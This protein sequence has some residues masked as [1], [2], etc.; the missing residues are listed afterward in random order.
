ML[1][2]K[3]DTHAVIVC[4]IVAITGLGI[5]F[6]FQPTLV[7]L[8]AHCTKSQ[9]AVVIADRNFFRCLG[10]ACGLAISAAILQATLR[11]NLPTQFAYLTHSSYSLPDR[12]A[13]TEIEWEQI[14][15]AYAQAS[16]SV[17]LFM[18]PVIALCF[19]ACV[20]VRDHG[21]ER[22]KDAQEIEEEKRKAAE[23]ARDPE[24]GVIEPV[25]EPVSEEGLPS[26]NDHVT[27]EVEKR[28]SMSSTLAESSMPPS[29]LEPVLTVDPHH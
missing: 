4:V 8:Q 15:D 20:L 10:G 23:A 28:H 29:Q 18:F 17:F 3:R 14:L 16:H 5:G 9:R 21:L 2:F 7:A 27:D 12:S 6:T 26:E 25:A 11:S 19:L 13:V 24:A 22:P 1:L